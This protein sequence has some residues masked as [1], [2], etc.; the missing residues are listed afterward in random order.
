MPPGARHAKGAL[1]SDPYRYQLPYRGRP[2]RSGRAA[3]P[4]LSGE[5]TRLETP[6]PIPNTAVK[7]PGPMV[8]PHA[9]E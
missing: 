5:Q 3:A 2:A 8:V 4:R 6:V 1:E 7:Q 9:R